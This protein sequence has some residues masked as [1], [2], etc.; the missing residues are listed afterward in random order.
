MKTGNKTTKRLAK[1]CMVLLAC[2]SLTGCA[3]SK[4]AK[5]DVYDPF[6]NV[7]RATFAF[8]DALDKAVAEPI[9]RGYRAVTPEPVRTGLRNFLRNLRSPVNIGNQV[10]QGDVQGASSDILR[11]M[12]NTTFGMGGLIDVA[13]HAGLEYEREDFGQTMAVWGFEDGAYMVLP[14]FGP[15]TVRDATGTLV[16]TLADPLRLYLHNTDQ[17]E[18]NYARLG[19]TALSKREELL[20]VL[21]DLRKNSFDYYAALRSSY[22]QRRKALVNDEDPD[23]VQSPSIPDYEEDL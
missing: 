15:S 10:L 18:W 20:D 5:Y 6:E 7:N 17:D 19:A 8:N 4:Q 13:G 23:A 3:G 14:L 9:A 16:D 2:A 21:E 22:V 11:V 1:F 12:I